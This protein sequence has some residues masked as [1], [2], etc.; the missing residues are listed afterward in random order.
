ML[1]IFALLAM[2]L[3]FM[4]GYAGILCFGHSAFFGF[5]AYVYAV[6]AINIGES[7]VPL[8]LAVFFPAIVAASRRDDVLRPHQRRYMGVITLVFSLIMFKFMNSTAGDQYIIGDARLGGFNGM[9]GF[10]TLNMPGCAHISFG[11]YR[12]ISLRRV[13]DRCVICCAV[14]Y[15]LALRP[16]VVGIRENETRCEFLGYDVPACKMA[17]FAIGGAMAGLA[18]CFFANWAEIVTPSVFSFSSRRK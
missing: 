17:I 18:G 1:L 8:L 4:W 10:P 2:S 7:P 11:V 9:P 6:A 14:G 3:G 16:H 12:P 13:L 5:G 15:S